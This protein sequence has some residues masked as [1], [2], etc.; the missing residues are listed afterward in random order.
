[1]RVRHCPLEDNKASVY[2]FREQDACDLSRAILRSL[3]R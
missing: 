3:L 2:R 1:M